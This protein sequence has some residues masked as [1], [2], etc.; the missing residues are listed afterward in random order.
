MII[1]TNLRMSV[2]RFC[3]VW[4]LT[5]SVSAKRLLS[6]YQRTWSVMVM[7]MVEMLMM[8]VMVMTVTMNWWPV[9]LYLKDDADG[10][11]HEDWKILR[12]CTSWFIFAVKVFIMQHHLFPIFWK[13]SFSF[14]MDL[15][16][17]LNFQSCRN[18]RWAE[19]N[20]V[21]GYSCYCYCY[22]HGTML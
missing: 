17:V 8:V 5:V 1:G 9:T 14:L 15:R 21:H 10:H 11:I 19:Q 6:R 2:C 3:W 4:K 22:R 7:A 20:E 16:E 13:C 18:K 12:F